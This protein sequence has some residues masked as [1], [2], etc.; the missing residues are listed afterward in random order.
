M[1]RRRVLWWEGKRKACKA[2]G[3]I[4]KLAPSEP[5]TMRFYDGG[6]VDWACNRCGLYNSIQKGLFTPDH[7]LFKTKP[8][9]PVRIKIM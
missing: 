2:C 8:V 7:K 4:H 6:R 1:P 3:E 9:G 5:I